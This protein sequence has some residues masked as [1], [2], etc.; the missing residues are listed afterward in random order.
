MDLRSVS[1]LPCLSKVLKRVVYTQVRKYLED[2]IILPDKQ[3][4]FRK[5]RGTATALCDVIGTILE[6]RDRKEGT[7]LPLLDYSRAFDAINTS[8]LLSKLAYYGFSPDSIQWFHTYLSNRSQQ[9]EIYREDQSVLSSPL[10]CDQ[11]RPTRFHIVA[12]F[13][14]IIYS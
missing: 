4:G 13:I 10:S 14:Y 5:G 9:V 7:I 11:G 2:N 1:I 3:S 12:P 8:L 6:A